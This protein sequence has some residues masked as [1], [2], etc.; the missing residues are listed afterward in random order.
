MSE[1]EKWNQRHREQPIGAVEP[2][3]VE[4]IARIPRGVALDVA[5]G[6]GRNSLAMARAGIRVIAVD[7]SVEAMRTLAAAARA[8]HLAVWPVVANLDNFYIRAGSLDAIVNVNFLERRLF[9]NFVR[10][11]RPGGILIADTFLIDQAEIGHPRN[12]DFLLNHGELPAL[13]AG[14]QVEDYREGLVTCPDG[15]KAYRASIVA[16]RTERS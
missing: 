4:M 1:R 7:F 12:P 15:T 16:R 8:E 11:L 13:V 9:P 5:A 2:F 6:R 10:A 3:L 14:L